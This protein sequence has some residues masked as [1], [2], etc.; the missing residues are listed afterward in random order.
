M[1]RPSLS[2]FDFSEKRAV[3][4]DWRGTSVGP[5]I[6]Q[7]DDSWVLLV[8][9]EGWRVIEFE[10]ANET[11]RLW[12]RFRLE[13]WAKQRSLDV[14]PL[15]KAFDETKIRRIPRGRGKESG[16]F[17]EK[18]GAREDYEQYVLDFAA[19]INRAVQIVSE[20]FDPQLVSE[21]MNKWRF[22]S[23]DATEKGEEWNDWGWYRDPKIDEYEAART[24]TLMGLPPEKQAE[25]NVRYPPYAGFGGPYINPPLDKILKDAPLRQMLGEELT[26]RQC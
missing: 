11:S 1:E 13:R 16:R 21:Y 26:A 17:A 3:P 24:K 15:V 5:R 18:P 10:G 9:G 19:N 8:D 12:S 20:A 14:V 7:R 4:R 6:V 25:F 22:E 2:L 23:Y